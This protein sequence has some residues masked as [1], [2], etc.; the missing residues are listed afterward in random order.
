M[1]SSEFLYY[2]GWVYLFSGLGV[3]LTM[4]INHNFDQGS[5]RASA[6]SCLLVGLL[7]HFVPDLFQDYLQQMLPLAFCGATFI[8]MSRTQHFKSLS[9]MLIAALI[10]TIVFTS[11]GVV[12]Q[13]FGGKLG[14][15]A[16]ISVVATIGAFAVKR[17]IAN[18]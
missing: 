6:V 11:S 17:R 9:Q 10:F 12:F 8:G 4:L 3:I 1:V 13:G 5:V 15:I 7:F 2:F 14:L 16:N 18:T